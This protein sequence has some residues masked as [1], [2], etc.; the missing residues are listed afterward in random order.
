VIDD[1][2]LRRKIDAGI[3]VLG[4]WNTFGSPLVTEAMARAGFDFQVVDLE[5]GPFV[6]DEVHLH[7]SACEAVGTC[8]PVVRIPVNE[9]WMSLQALDQGAHGVMVP[10]VEGGD[11]AALLA[12]SL[13]YYPEGGRGFTPF[14][15]A[16]HFGME[17][18]DEHVHS[19]NGRVVGLVVVE[20]LEGL[21]GVEAIAGTPGIDVVY[22][23]AYDLSQALGRP[24]ESTHPAVMEAIADGVEK[25][26]RAGA[27]PGG[28]V[29]RSREE[30]AALLEM[31][32]GFI[33]YGVDSWLLADRVADMAGWFG[34]R[35]E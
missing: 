35:V 17:P 6:L 10:H 14:S 34:E 28:F 23:G 8:S 12:G 30:V 20:S 9:P 1:S 27:C 16:G 21:A 15:K 26:R 24:G 18:V 33:T 3:P 4:T 22:F 5:H 2:P 7:A 29:P 25:V 13:R 32:M 11:E 31:G 19:S